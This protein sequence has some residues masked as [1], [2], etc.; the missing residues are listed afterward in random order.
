MKDCFYV[1]LR[2]YLRVDGVI[3][4]SL[5]TR[6]FGDFG[7]NYMLR[8]FQHKEATIDELRM[9]GFIPDSEWMLSKTQA[10]EVN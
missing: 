2:S 8:E 10:D 7:S 4:R 5:D 1:L 9:K 6:I 3:V